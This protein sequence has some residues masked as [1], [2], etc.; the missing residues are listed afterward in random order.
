MP[1]QIGACLQRASTGGWRPARRVERDVEECFAF[2]HVSADDEEPHEGRD[3]SLRSVA[4]TA[5]PRPANR[6]AQVGPLLFEKVGPRILLAALE[7]RF[8]GLH[9]RSEKGGVSVANGVEFPG[10]CQLLHRVVTDGFKQV[11]TR[12]RPPVRHL[13]QRS[14][15]QPCK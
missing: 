15:D 2:S 5:H 4:V 7:V 9:Q 6:A 13:D 10:S 14:V 12:E 1:P 8:R 3:E 11:V